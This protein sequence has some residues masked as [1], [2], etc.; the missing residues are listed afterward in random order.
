MDT[1]VMNTLEL[2]LVLGFRFTILLGA[3]VGTINSIIKCD[4]SHP[5]YPSCPKTESESQVP[6][7]YLPQD[8]HAHTHI[9]PTC[10]A[11]ILEGRTLVR[12]SEDASYLLN[13]VI[14]AV[15]D[16]AYPVVDAFQVRWSCLVIDAVVDLACSIVDAYYVVWRAVA[17]HVRT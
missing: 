9:G 7:W 4:I 16:L 6:C 14:D 3:G 5:P 11:Q 12:R 8:T 1:L 2:R 10:F 17:Q 13:L 15:V